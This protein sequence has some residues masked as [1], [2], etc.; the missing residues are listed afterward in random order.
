MR[1]EPLNNLRLFVRGKGTDIKRIGSI[2]NA[3]LVDPLLRIPQ[4]R[5]DQRERQADLPGV[6]NGRE[7]CACGGAVSPRRR[8]ASSTARMTGW[9]HW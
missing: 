1:T 7:G 3:D 2:G 5:K 4:T 8:C 9:I 6:M